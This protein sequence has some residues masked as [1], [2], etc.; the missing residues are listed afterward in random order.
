MKEKYSLFLLEKSIDSEYKL[1]GSYL[2]ESCFK[3]VDT[4]DTL[5]EAQ[6]AQKEFK[7]KTIILASW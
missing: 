4:Y 5:E 1:I 7:Q 2:S 6:L 3:C